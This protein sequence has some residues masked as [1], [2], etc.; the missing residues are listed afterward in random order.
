MTERL[1]SKRLTK[2]ERLLDAYDFENLGAE[3]EVRWTGDGVE[4]MSLRELATY[5]NHRVL[6]RVLL[7]A[8]MSALEDDVSSIYHKLTAD[9]VTTGVQTATR[10]RLTQN[11][12][13]VDSLRRDFVT[14]QAIRTYL[15]ERRG[16]EHTGDSDSEKRRKDLEQIQRLLARARVVTEERIENLRNTDRMDID[17]FEVFIDAQVLCQDCGAQYTVTDLFE[18]HGCDCSDE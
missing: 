18:Q 11:G 15:Q 6:E 12:I 7:D 16:V 4:R 5:F 8:G 10:T 2:V 3:L 14:Y 13:D 17:D 1:Q 9:T